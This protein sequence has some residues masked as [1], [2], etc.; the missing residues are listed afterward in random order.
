M[1][2]WRAS[3]GLLTLLPALLLHSGCALLQGQSASASASAAAGPGQALPADPARP[4]AEAAA[5]GVRI[6]IVAPAEIKTLLQRHLDAVRLGGLARGDVED[7]EWA[8]LI[9]AAPA[10][11]R[12]LLQ[13]EGYFAPQVLLQR[14]PGHAAGQPEAV[15]LEVTPGTRARVSRVTIEAE[16]ELER[17]ASAG[18][19]HARATLAQLRAS[20]ALP[21]GSDFRN[22]AW[23][24][25]KAA[26]LARLRAAGYANAVWSGT[27]AEVDAAK[28]EVRIF[29]VADSGPLFRYGGLLVE[30]LAA[31]DAQTV[32]NLAATPLGAPLTETLLLDFQERLQKSGLF[33]SVSVTLDPDPARAA[34]ARV[35]VR[36]RESPLQVYTFGVGF[37]ANTGARASVEHVYR[38]VFGFA[39]T[40]RNKIEWGQRRQA[41]NGEISTHPGVSLYRSLVGGAVER[42]QTDSDTVL[43]QRLRL[44][45]TQDTQRLERLYFVEAERSQRQALDQPRTDAF[46]LSFNYHGAWR[47]LDSVVLPTQ[48]FTFSG[49]AGVGRSH[50]SHADA[51]Y[52]TRA[53]GRLTGYLPLGRS[54][55]GQARIEVGQVFLRQ[56]LVVP[57]S[58]SFRA[59]G[60]DSVRGYSYRSLGPLVDGVVGSGKSLL[61]TSLELARPISSSVPSLWGA[62][63]A[64]A[65]NAADSFAN[66]KP[67]LGVG[68]GLRWRSPVGPL[69]LDWAWGRETRRARLHF[70][71][72]IAF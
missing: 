31:Q 55:Y 2:G 23:G 45:R 18:E 10:Q 49:Q 32:Q 15:R 26:A 30:G 34:A 12:E 24:D 50:G 36:L 11:V 4:A 63:F 46:A 29:L 40:A 14:Q 42:L 3:A 1:K 5:L 28:N 41:W 72:G 39:A 6:E 61:T 52:F 66:L 16:G 13:T 9:D 51:G 35:L 64:D 70:S 20:W 47:E 71:V 58:Q 27:G 56:G 44:G 57:D 53:Y 25:A 22:P 33:D 59:G 69:R 68:I 48:G 19:A 21:A 54:L 65:G 62:V 17:G 37:S 7:S 43:S 38:R 67:A 60:D 8:R